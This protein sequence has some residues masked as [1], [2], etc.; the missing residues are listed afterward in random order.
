MDRVFLVVYLGTASRSQLQETYYYI[1]NLSD[2]YGTLS[3]L[4]SVCGYHYETLEAMVDHTYQRHTDTVIICKLCRKRVSRPLD[5]MLHYNKIQCRHPE[6]N[7]KYNGCQSCPVHPA[8]LEEI[9]GDR[10]VTYNR[11]IG[12][13]LRAYETPLIGDLIDI[14]QSYLPGFSSTKNDKRKRDEEDDESVHEKE[15]HTS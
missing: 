4:S 13:L 3:C 9:L 15:T 8:R 2:F 7:E 6:C 10:D 14:V 1:W 5:C 12:L 11:T